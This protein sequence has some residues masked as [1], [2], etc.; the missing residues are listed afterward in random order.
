[1][2][3]QKSRW[4]ALSLLALASCATHYIPNTDVEDNDENRKVIAFCEKYRHAV[5]ERNVPL[6]LSMASPR[7]YE[8]GGNVD[9]T[10]DMDFAGL[11]DY[12]EGRFKDTRAIRY[13][14]R[15]RKVNRGPQDK[16]MVDYTYS[17]SYKI[18][19]I[20]GEEWRHTVADNR[21]ELVPDQA[22]YKILAGI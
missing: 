15:Y 22:A 6:L 4:F 10:D 21:L 11:R 3:L 16:I 13:E 5:E 20:K 1:M 2:K 14:I 7:Y 8:D 19:G 18:P 9:A 17:A 12:L